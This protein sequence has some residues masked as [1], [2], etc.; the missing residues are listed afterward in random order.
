MEFIT[1]LNENSGLAIIQESA[2]HDNSQLR[3]LCWLG[4]TGYFTLG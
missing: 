1:M 3:P 4:I 2:G